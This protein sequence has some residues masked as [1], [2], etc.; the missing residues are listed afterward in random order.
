MISF[1]GPATQA[2]LTAKADSLVDHSGRV[3]APIVAGIDLGP[4]CVFGPQ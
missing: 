1:A 4:Y 2:E 3:V